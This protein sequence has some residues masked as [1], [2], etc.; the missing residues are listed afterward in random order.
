MEFFLPEY[1]KVFYVFTDAAYLPFQENGNVVIKKNPYV[2]WPIAS[3]KRFEL[4]LSIREQILKDEC[5]YLFFCNANLRCKKKIEPSDLGIDD[6]RVK[7]IV[8]KHPAYE[9]KKKWRFPY[10]R[11]PKCTAY[12]PYNCGKY[13]VMGSFNGG[14]TADYL[15]MADVLNKNEIIDEKNGIISTVY[16]ESHLN[17]YVS[18]MDEKEIKVL[19]SAYCSDYRTPEERVAIVMA[20]KSEYFNENQIKGRIKQTQ[21]RIFIGKIKRFLM[22]YCN[23]VIDSLLKKQIQS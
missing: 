11:N 16:D 15:C 7:I 3:H 18:L 10:D 2:G 21:V 13:Y 1:E 22:A 9:F 6:N 5:S 4:F 14:R 8:A 17:Y 12:I 19:S 23:Y 20:N